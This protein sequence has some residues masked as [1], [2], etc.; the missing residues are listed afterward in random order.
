MDKHKDFI[1]QNKI[2]F[3]I[4]FAILFS[5]VIYNLSDVLDVAGKFIGLFK[6]LFIAIVIAFIANIP[7]HHFENWL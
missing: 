4:I 7:M 5:Y 6:P 3:Y 1:E 2:I